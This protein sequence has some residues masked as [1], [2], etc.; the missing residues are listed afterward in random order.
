MTYESIIPSF[1]FQA[2]TRLHFGLSILERSS[3][4]I[5]GEGPFLV[6]TYSS[7]ARLSESLDTLYKAIGPRPY[8]LFEGISPNPRVSE[9]NMGAQVGIDCGAKAVIGLGGG[10][11]M[12]AAKG[13]AVVI[14]SSEPVEFFLRQGHPAPSE[15]LPIIAIPTTAGT[16]SEMSAGAVLT[17]EELGIKDTLRGYNLQPSVAIVDPMLTLSMPPRITAET[18]FDVLTHAV[19]TWISRRSTPVTAI[20]SE[21][22]VKTVTEVLPHLL[23]NPEDLDSR[24]RMSLVSALM[25]INL[26]NSST[27]LPHRLQYPLGALTD[28]SHAA[29][30]AALY[31]AWVE[32]T[33]HY[34]PELLNKITSLLIGDELFGRDI[35]PSDIRS[36]FE[37]FQKVLGLPL[38]L[39]D[40]GVT[41]DMIPRL[42]SKVRGNLD[43]DPGNV[44]TSALEA[45]YRSA[46]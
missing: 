34:C 25:G 44:T 13:I 37:Q 38:R 9:I 11:V 35:H 26:T 36:T 6:V 12:D 32:T 28:T 31:P 21:F 27:C 46:F 4:L 19:E 15:T 29:G 45:L 17:D 22:A 16:G 40:L 18:G 39:E 41:E 2:S 3:A 5:P 14:G 30:L 1:S 24:S 33:Y 20:L 43:N 7:E 10:S 42:V 8:A 23:K